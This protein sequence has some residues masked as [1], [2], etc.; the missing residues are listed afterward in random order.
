[1]P[2]DRISLRQLLALLFAA[3]L[4]PAIGV[5]PS[6]T[7][8]LAGEAGWLSA[9]AALPVLLGLCWVLFALLRPAGEGAG[10]AQVTET[11]LGRG[12]GKGVLL[13]Y[14]LWG[15][16]LLSANARLFA[17]RF[18]STSY[19][20]APL[21]LFLLILLGLTLWLVRKPVRVLA[22]TGEVFYLALAIGLGFSLI[23][24]VLQVE[25]R[26][27]LPLWTEDLPGV[28]SAAV[29]VLGLFGYVVFAAFLG[30]NVT[31]G[32]GDRRRALWWAAAFCLVLTALQLVCLGNFGPGLTARMDTPF[33]MMVKGIGIEG[34][35]QRVESVIIALW[36]FSDLALLNLLAG[37]C[38]VL[39]QSVFS[40]KERKHAVLPLLLLALAGAWFLFPDAF[41]LERWM[42]GP[43][44]MG[45]LLFGFGIPVLLLL[46]KKLRRQVSG[47][48]ILCML[49]SRIPVIRSGLT[50]EK[51][52]EK[53]R[54]RC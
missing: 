2:D 29:P 11:V 42:E 26:H 44:R 18:L 10:L 34:T 13:L 7:A 8:A 27:I 16:L 6:Q 48:Q 53:K 45:S 23:L 12:L 21:G 14:L 15:L 24:G 41:S 31:R 25:P 22:R 19:R 40:L 51:K 47:W 49:W 33:F 50:A 36:V 28:L 35:F 17:L 4:A 46:V 9:L 39:A 30:G 38:S 43:A 5:L 54:K 20:N 32:E 3:L 37:S 1:M 52:T